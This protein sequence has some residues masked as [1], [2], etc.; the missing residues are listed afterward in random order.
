MELVSEHCIIPSFL[1]SQAAQPSLGN[2]AGERSHLE[3]EIM[4]KICRK[5][6][7]QNGCKFS[8]PP[9]A[10]LGGIGYSES[11]TFARWNGASLRLATGAELKFGERLRSIVQLTATFNPPL[12]QLDRAVPS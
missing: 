10:Q 8:H 6:R 9:L 5:G 7:D 12:A 1:S 3:L 2:S 11:I 4:C